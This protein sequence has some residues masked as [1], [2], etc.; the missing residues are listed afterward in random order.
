MKKINPPIVIEDRETARKACLGLLTVPGPFGVDC[1]TIGIDPTKEAPGSGKGRIFCWSIAFR[2]SPAATIERVYLSRDTLPE[3]KAWL[4]DPRVKKVGHNI[5]GFDRHMFLNEGIHLDGICGDTLHMSKLSYNHPDMRHGLKPLSE[6]ILGYKMQ[7]YKDLFSRPKQLL[8]KTYKKETKRTVDGVPTIFWPGTVGR[9]SKSTE[10]IPLDELPENYPQRMETL[11]DYAS[12]DAQC[13]LELYHYFKGKL[14]DTAWRPESSLFDFYEQ[15]WNPALHVLGA[16]ERN[17]MFLDAEV[18]SVALEEMGTQ[19]ISQAERLTEWLGD[20]NI[21]SPKQ[22][23]E[24]LYVYKD[25]PVPPICG[26]LKAVKRTKRGERPTSEAAIQWLADNTEDG[27]WFRLLIEHR[28]MLKEVKRV[29][30]FL[31]HR[32]E[33]GRV[34]YSLSP[35][36][37]TGRLA[38]RNIPIQQVPKAGD[39]RKAFKASPGHQ[40]IVADYSQLELYLLAH[41]LKKLFGDEVLGD[42]LMSGDVHTATAEDLGLDRDTTKAVIYSVN[43]G[44]GYKGLAAQLGIEP[45]EAAGILEVFH[46]GIPTI[47]KF[48]SWCEGYAGRNG[49]IRTLLGRYRWIPELGSDDKFEYGVGYRKS[50]NTPIQGSAADLVTMAM[51]KTNVE[52]GNGAPVNEELRALGARFLCQVHDELIFEVPEENAEAA[53]EIVISCME[54]P[55]EKDLHFP[56]PVNATICG[57]WADGK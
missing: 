48:H 15:V 53:K 38:A 41:F 32:D 37:D 44:K 21:R 42:R 43:Y 11:Y 20:I 30:T 40:L 4:E 45:Y 22:L 55:L 46:A 31:E 56:T 29:E 8:P 54:H 27:D 14:L 57:S 13:T 25:Y 7:G 12:L 23:S 50:I 18:C 26:S 33:G 51:L 24:F 3:F 9:F 17:G 34:H 19:V 10:L 39:L 52:P 16:A 2:K 35:S 5:F 49:Y 28:K 1:E 47:K 6:S 36:T